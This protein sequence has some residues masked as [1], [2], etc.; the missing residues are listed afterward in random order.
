MNKVLLILLPFTPLPF[1]FWPKQNEKMFFISSKNDFLQ[2]QFWE[3]MMCNN[4]HLICFYIK[5]SFRTVCHRW[6][7]NRG[8]ENKEVYWCKWL[9]TKISLRSCLTLAFPERFPLASA[10]EVICPLLLWCHS[11]LFPSFMFL[12]GISLFVFAFY[13]SL[14]H[15]NA[16]SRLHFIIP[17]CRTLH[18]ISIE[19]LLNEWIH[20]ENIRLL[21]T[22][23]WLAYQFVGFF[24]F[25]FCFGF[26]FAF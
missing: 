5:M 14:L 20:F 3:K 24:G 22:C 7:M 4:S 15:W 26:I 25:L 2:E 11:V 9:N 12:S 21:T 18:I 8:T 1:S 13:R 16:N 10:S 17:I 23:S 19:Y 6:H